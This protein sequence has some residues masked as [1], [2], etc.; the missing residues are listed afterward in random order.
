MIPKVLHIIWVGDEARR[1]DNCIRTWVEAQ[2]GVVGLAVG[3]DDL[4][5]CGWFNARHMREMAPL[6]LNRPT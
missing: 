5:G 2:P 4:A 3:N 6:E 1:P